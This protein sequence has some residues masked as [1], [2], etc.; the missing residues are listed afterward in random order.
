[1]SVQLFDLTWVVSSQVAF[2]ELVQHPEYTYNNPQN[3]E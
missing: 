2:V 1:M 3:D